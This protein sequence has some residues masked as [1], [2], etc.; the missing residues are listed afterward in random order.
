M[1]IVNIKFSEPNHNGDS[2]YYPTQYISELLKKKFDG[3]RY[4]SSLHAGGMN[5]ALFNTKKDES[6]KPLNYKIKNSAIHI[7]K[8]ISI[9]QERLLPFPQNYFEEQWTWACKNLNWHGLA[10]ENKQI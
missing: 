4:R 5:I 6:G 1:E 8:G 9:D 10:M 3:I 2:G 7:V